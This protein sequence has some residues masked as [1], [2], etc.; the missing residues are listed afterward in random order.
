MHTNLKNITKPCNEDTR[1][2]LQLSLMY[3]SHLNNIR[4]R[5]RLVGRSHHRAIAA[6][7]RRDR[8]QHYMLMNSVPFENIIIC[9]FRGQKVIKTGRKTT[10]TNTYSTVNFHLIDPTR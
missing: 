8:R 5:V 1:A 10:F 7:R 3:Y 6:W 4:F 9:S 2:I